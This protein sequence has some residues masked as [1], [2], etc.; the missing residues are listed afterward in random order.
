MSDLIL[1]HIE[2]I[3]NLAHIIVASVDQRCIAQTISLIVD[4]DGLVFTSR[5]PK[6]PLFICQI[7]PTACSELKFNVVVVNHT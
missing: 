4:V 3:K 1:I 7:I 6:A 5:S 2:I